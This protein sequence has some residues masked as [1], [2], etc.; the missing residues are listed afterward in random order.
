MSLFLSKDNLE[1]LLGE[2]R[3][4]LVTGGAGFIGSALIRRLL[5]ESDAKIF[6]VDKLSYASDLR[7]IQN[8]SNSIPNFNQRYEFLHLDLCNFEKTLVSY[9][10]QDESYDE[11]YDNFHMTMLIWFFKQSK[12]FKGGD[13]KFNETNEVI[14][15]EHNRA[16]FFPSFYNYQVTPIKFD[17]MQSGR[18]KL[19]KYCITHFFGHQ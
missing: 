7:S 14:E 16:L 1:K 3:K 17:V 15:C 9:Y 4:I 10:S 19:G 6:N 13:L 8:L 5:C 11:Q 18:E 2:K 12:K